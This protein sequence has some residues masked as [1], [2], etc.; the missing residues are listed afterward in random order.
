MG[1]VERTEADADAPAGGIVVPTQRAPADVAAV[2]APSNPRGRV[3]T[4]GHPAP[5]VCRQVLPA[6][7]VIR[8]VAPGVVRHPGPADGPV[9]PATTVVRPPVRGD[10]RNPDHTVRGIPVPLPVVVQLDRVRTNLLRNLL[11]VADIAGGRA[12][13]DP[14]VG[15]AAVLH[16]AVKGV[17][18]TGIDH[19]R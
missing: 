14:Q 16:V 9:E 18:V 12:P 6:P 13:R 2:I 11:L 19:S 7:V 10:R 4:A 8:S 3:D 5:A 17:G 1:G 15:Q